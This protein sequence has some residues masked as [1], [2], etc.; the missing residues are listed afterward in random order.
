MTLID[1]IDKVQWID[2]STVP[3]QVLLSEA[4]GDYQWNWNLIQMFV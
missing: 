2:L 1:L 3:K 4:A